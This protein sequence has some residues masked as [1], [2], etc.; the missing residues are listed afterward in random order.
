MSAH[1]NGPPNFRAECPASKISLELGVML[2]LAPRPQWVMHPLDAPAFR[3]VAETTPAI[4]PSGEVDLC[5]LVHPDG[6][7]AASP[8]IAKGVFRLPL[9][10]QSRSQKST[11]CRTRFPW[12]ATV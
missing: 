11:K 10:F 12:T 3:R 9:G 2:S 1:C 7:D 8:I 5:R 6:Q 4:P